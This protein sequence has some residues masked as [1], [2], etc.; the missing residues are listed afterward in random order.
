MKERSTFKWILERISTAG[1]Y[2]SF[3]TL[4]YSLWLEKRIIRI[5][6][7]NKTRRHRAQTKFKST[8]NLNG[9]QFSLVDATTRP[10]A[11]DAKAIGPSCRMARL[12]ASSVASLSWILWAVWLS[13]PYKHSDPIDGVCFMLPLSENPSKLA[14]QHQIRFIEWTIHCFESATAS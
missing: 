3:F 11:S 2:T 6:Q 9:L 1:D 12:P 10:S 4:H 8:L 14:H 7:Q 5:F 13:S